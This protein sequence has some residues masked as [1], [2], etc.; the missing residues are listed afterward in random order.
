MTPTVAPSSRFDLRTAR[1]ATRNMT[2]GSLVALRC[3]SFEGV[4][5]ARNEL[6]EF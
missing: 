3:V 6:T 1:R 5:V 4:E 2:E